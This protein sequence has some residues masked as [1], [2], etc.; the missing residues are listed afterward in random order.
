VAFLA[1][2]LMIVGVEI[3]KWVVRRRDAAALQS[4]HA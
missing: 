3:Q 2:G 1:G 4:Q